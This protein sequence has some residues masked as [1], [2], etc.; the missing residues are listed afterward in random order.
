MTSLVSM[1]HKDGRGGK[2]KRSFN[3][4]MSVKSS[5]GQ[6]KELRRGPI[7]QYGLWPLGGVI[8]AVKT[9]NICYISSGFGRSK[10]FRYDPDLLNRNALF[11]PVMS[12]L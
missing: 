1:P 11:L 9:A 12:N 2:L 10:V 3:L 4:T 6:D 8:L 5:M 7:E